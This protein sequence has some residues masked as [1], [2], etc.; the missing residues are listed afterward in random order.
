MK[1]NREPLKTLD[2][3]TIE[4]DR[5]FWG[6]LSK[7]LLADP[8]FLSSEEARKTYA[9]LRSAIGGLYVYRHLTNEAE[10]A[11]KQAVG[12]CPASFE[13]N[14]RLAQLYVEAG[15]FDDAITVLEQFQRR[16]ATTDTHVTAAISRI[17]EM[18]L[19]A[20]KKQAK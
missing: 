7:E 6:K 20:E 14:F 12:L 13:P 9:K 15:R 11:F 16:L 19:E 2:P 5:E 3:T 1:L 4:Q 10:V 18:K 17:R 8:K